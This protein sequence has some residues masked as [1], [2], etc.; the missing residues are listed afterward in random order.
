MNGGG[1]DTLFV[2]YAPSFHGVSG[3]SLTFRQSRP[4]LKGGVVRRTVWQHS[5][6][7][8]RRLIVDVGEY[9]NPGDVQ[10][11][12][13]AETR[14]AGVH[15]EAGPKFLGLG[16]LVHPEVN[17]WS[18]YATRA[19]LLIWGLSNGQE[20]LAVDTLLKPMLDELDG[21]ASADVDQQLALTRG[22]A[23]PDAPGAIGL[24]FTPEWDLGEWAWLKF[25]ASG[26]TL[27]RGTDPKTLLVRP[28]GPDASVEVTGWVIEPGRKTYMGRF[29][30]SGGSAL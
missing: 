12:L 25:Q 17:P 30:T 26:A 13:A 3:W 22:A 21:I 11:A 1:S 9:R 18:I 19:N 6:D 28:N 15:Y 2:G 14:E 24:T 16:A 27:E 5:T 4:G 10:A 23:W 29:T 7:P 20:K 8:H